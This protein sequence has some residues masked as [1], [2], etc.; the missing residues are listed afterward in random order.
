MLLLKK[1]KWRGDA[2]WAYLTSLDE[3]NVGLS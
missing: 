1:N 2:H 3:V